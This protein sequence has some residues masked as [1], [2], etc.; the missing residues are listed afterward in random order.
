VSRLP[1][2][3]VAV[4]VAVSLAWG[5]NFLA[6]AVALRHF[7]PI[8]FTSLRLAVV[9]LCLL[10]FLLP[11]PRVQRGRLVAIALC[12]GALHFGLNF[13]ALR[14]AG[15]ISSVAIALQSYV[16]LTALLGAVF[17]GE[18]VGLRRG[19]GIAIAFSGVLVLGFDPLVLDAPLALGLCLTAA[20][21][22]AVGTTLM[23]GLGG[24]GAFAL[25]G[26]IAAIG[27]PPLL[28]AACFLEPGAMQAIA[29]AGWKDWAGVAYSALIASIV[30]HGLLYWLVRRH[31]V[32]QV[33]PYFLLAP[34]FAV[35]LGVLVWGDAP[36]PRLWIGGAA[37]LTGVLVVSLPAPGRRSSD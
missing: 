15:D 31:P 33:T 32:S 5:G 3:H 29:S 11:M 22:L 19:V 25:Q 20:L 24:I 30:G 18:Q 12:N 37:V 17:L 8:T 23:R 4:T 1:W 7:E 28:V 16:P 9:L 35:A 34:V 21:S 14:V 10:P 13:A 2:S 26:W 27:L 6:S 36:G